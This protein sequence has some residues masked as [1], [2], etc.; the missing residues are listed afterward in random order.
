MGSVFFISDAHLGLEANEVENRRERLLLDFLSH[1]GRKGEGLYIVGDLFDFW[2]EYRSVIPR[3]Y[4]RVL[5][6][7]RKLVEQGVKIRY[8]TGNHD[9]WMESFFDREL[10]VEVYQESLDIRIEGKR[11]YIAHGDG[12]A[13][14]D[15]GYR[16]L[17]KVLRHPLNVR[18]YRLLHPDI[19]FALARFFSR[20]SRDCREIKDRD[21]EYLAYAKAL[22]A[23]GFDCVVL[24][25]THRPQEFR[26]NGRTYINTGDWMNGF[27]Y[28]KFAQGKLR[29]ETWPTETAAGPAIGTP[30]AS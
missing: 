23:Q 22:F 7:L 8:V 16:L 9:F 11:F 19:G 27:T 25:H 20:L 5:F 3:R 17:K 29:I 14:K 15:D 30:G 24:A 6:A 21:T 2:F 4:F 13:K 28:G 18:L 1:V 10:G 12:L 26:K